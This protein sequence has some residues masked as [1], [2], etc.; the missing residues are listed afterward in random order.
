MVYFIAYPSAQPA[1][2]LHFSK[3]ASTIPATTL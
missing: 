2:S 1:M 3:L